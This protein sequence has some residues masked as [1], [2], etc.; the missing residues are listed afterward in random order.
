MV[1]I[2]TEHGKFFFSDFIYLLEE[3][4][5][6]IDETVLK[7]NDLTYLLLAYLTKRVTMSEEDLVKVKNKIKELSSTGG[8]VMPDLSD[9]V[10]KQ[11]LIEEV[12]KLRGDLG[13]E[14][15]MESI[16]QSLTEIDRLYS[17]IETK[18][19]EVPENLSTTVTELQTFKSTVETDYTKKTDLESYATL[20]HFDTLVN[21]L[22]LL[23]TDKA[24]EAVAKVVDGAP[25]TFDTLKEI[26]T[27]IENNG[28]DASDL[29][30]S[31]SGKADKTELTNYSTKQYVDTKVSTSKQFRGLVTDPFSISNPQP[32]D[33]C[34][35]LNEGFYDF[36]FY[37]ND[38]W[39]TYTTRINDTLINNILENV[40]SDR[41]VEGSSNLYY[42]RDRVV[43]VVNSMINIS[44]IT[45]S[46]GNLTE[47]VGG[48]KTNKHEI[49]TDCS[50]GIFVRN[51]EVVYEKL[52]RNA[53]QSTVDFTISSGTN[54]TIEGT[55]TDVLVIDVPMD[56]ES[57][58]SWTANV[59]NIF[60]TDTKTKLQFLASNGSVIF[61][62]ESI[63]TGTYKI[64][65]GGIVVDSFSF[66]KVNK[67]SV[68]E[69][70]LHVEGSKVNFPT[71]N[72]SLPVRQ[73][74]ISRGSGTSPINLGKLYFKNI[75]S[76]KYTR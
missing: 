7:I 3:Q 34:I 57:E 44:S 65:T 66:S 26:A 25:A 12:F 50:R 54:L 37:I 23:A 62:I 2:T 55:E 71:N 6:D 4:S 49:L 1:K 22:I 30:A 67:I 72:F 10:T 43:S 19:E 59:G 8:G 48:I 14:I 74:K 18:I 32:G 40:T 45:S 60:A 76:L 27:W 17:E 36:Y 39:Y 63:S 68:I 61:S 53:E 20:D 5:A 15:T 70:I 29:A 47:T 16:S 33:Y 11:E 42:N 28:V 56:I 35:K 69:G 41:I 75:S 13:E 46:I 58:N 21:N 73:L 38:Y 64:A 52:V 9:Y 24:N 51:G 31:I